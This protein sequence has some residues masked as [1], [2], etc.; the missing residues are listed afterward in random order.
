MN[1]T[2]ETKKKL[3]KLRV[4]SGKLKAVIYRGAN[5]PGVN[6]QFY[7]DVNLYGV[8][9]ALLYVREYERIGDYK[10]GTAQEAVDL[11]Q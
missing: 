4:V 10:E 9:E 11:F 1:I 3:R 5:N 6:M 2:D 8:Y 7:N